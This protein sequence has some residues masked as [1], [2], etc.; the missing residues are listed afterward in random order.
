[1][2]IVFVISS[3][4]S[5]GAERV[6]TTLANYWS[7]KGWDV[8]ILAILSHD[9]NFYKLHKNI[10]LI[11]LDM[12]YKNSLLNTLWYLY[13]IRKIVKRV[14]PNY[15]VSFISGMNIFTL[16]S[17][18]GLKKKIVISERN[19]FDVLKSKLW[20]RLRRITY[21]LTNGLVVLSEDDYN[22][23]TYVKNKK[24]IFNPLKIENLLDCKFELKEK[25]IIAVGTLTQQKGF[26]RL[27]RSL[28]DIEML[29]WRVEIIGEGPKR[30]EL[31]ALIKELNLEKTIFLI[32][33]KSNIY[34]YY[35]KASIFVLSS[36]W[37]GF[38]NVLSE[39]MAHGCSC[40]AFNCKTGPSS[41]IEH[42]KNGY[43]VEDGNT[44]ELQSRIVEVMKSSD[45]RQNF[46][47]NALT[48]REK[49]KV[50]IIVKEWENYLFSLNQKK[51][52]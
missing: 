22:H 25:L 29:D 10:K 31:T 33:R 40:I 43:L 49:L 15:V 2:K 34:D 36:H 26:D 45:L 14:N 7:E 8:T 4:T 38:P 21:P 18:I 32:G 35:Q 3:L 24:I 47:V 16:I 6:L 51:E 19:Y 9:K 37:E 28:A 20:R 12:R 52:N 1:M 46:F 30:E 23:Y 11:S 13:G 42:E 50:D 5:G 48:I 39:A 41:I 27:I 17:L 44:E